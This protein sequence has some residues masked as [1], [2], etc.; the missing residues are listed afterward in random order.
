MAPATPRLRVLSV[1]G[2]PLSAFLSWRLQATLSCDVTLVWKTSYES[3]SQYGI[4]F[5]SS[6]Y[7]NERFKPHAVVRT[8]EEAGTMSGGF[9]YVLLS[10]K[11]LPDVYDLAS[12]IE[13]VVTPQHTCILVNTTTAIGTEAYLESRYPTNVVLSL[14]SGVALSQLGNSEFEHTGGSD[15]WVGSA[16]QN[17]NIPESIQY[18]MAEALALTLHSGNVD[19]HVSPNIRQ[20]QWERML[21]PIAFHPLSVILDTPNLNALFE[22][23]GCKTLITGVVDELISIAKAQKCTFPEEFKQKTIDDQLSAHPSANI[24]YQDYQA[25]RPLE[26]ETFLGSPIKAAKTLGV[27]TPHLNT[28]YPVL[29]HL[30]QQNQSRPNPPSPSA[31]SGSHH[32]RM[33]GP[34]PSGQRLPPPNGTGPGG[35]PRRPPPGPSNGHSGQGSDPAMA[36]R[37]PPQS[38]GPSNGHPPHVNGAFSP[39]GQLSRRNSFD[40][41]LEEFG[42]IALYGDMVDSDA[43]PQDGGYR[44]HP[45]RGDHGNHVRQPPPTMSELDLRERKLALREREQALREQ[46]LK[47]SRFG[48]GRKKAGKSRSVYGDDDDDDDFYVD[49]P[50]PMPPVDVDNF[51]MMSVTSRRNRRLPSASSVNV[52]SPG[53]EIPLQPTRTGRHSMF[54]RNQRSRTSARLMNDVPGL[55]DPITD[56]AMMGYSSNRYGTVDRKVMMESSRA[57]SMTSNRGG[58]I[59]SDPSFGGGAY[60]PMPGSGNGNGGSGAYPPMPRRMSTSQGDPRN[61]YN[62]TPRNVNGHSPPHNGHGQPMPKHAYPHQ[63][64]HHIGDGVRQPSIMKGPTGNQVRSTTGSASAS[65]S[66]DSGSAGGELSAYSSS[67][68]SLEKRIPNGVAVV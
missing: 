27:S 37:P 12:I 18:D 41:D 45:G 10:V 33:Q 53:A 60:P 29:S 64:D 4:S 28:L 15:I 32:P 65:L 66:N 19:C 52:R 2:N 54:G 51:D 7:G 47:N 31:V 11:A 39:R 8:P 3:V 50:P 23:P 46:E 6:K 21:G 67:S 43:V 40:N 24:M 26:I 61:G 56:N 9:D 34:P 57:N 62:A 5:K 44:Q 13:S 25:R 1:G 16:I 42:H 35:A 59:R 30:N 48:F 36:R 49:A 22:K 14:V 58:D 17:T 68:S 55:H 63:V 20:Q 38:R